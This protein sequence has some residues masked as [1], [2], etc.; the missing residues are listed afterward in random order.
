MIRKL[1]LALA[2]F[3]VT[4]C[5]GGGGEVVPTSAGSNHRQLLV[6]L[7]KALDA[8]PE[9]VLIRGA[10]EMDGQYCALGALAKERGLLEN[11]ADGF[12]IAEVFGVEPEEVFEIVRV[13]DG[14]IEEDPAERWLGVR[15]WVRSKLLEV[16]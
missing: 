8:M 10:F 11:S 14:L 15:E 4:S 9:K 3:L 5:G 2:F 13:N 1:F 7:A 16:P 12:R 6:A